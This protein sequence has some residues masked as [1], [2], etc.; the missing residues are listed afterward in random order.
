MVQLSFT[1]LPAILLALRVAAGPVLVNENP[2]T[3]DISRRF[4]FAGCSV[5][6]S[7]LARINAFKNRSTVKNGLNARNVISETV[8]NRAFNY[9]A[10]VGVGSPA[11]FY[12]LVVDTGSSNTWIG[13]GNNYVV[14]STSTQTS[15]S[16]VSTEYTDQVT[17]APGLV[18]SKQSIGVA[19][20]SSGFDEGID[21]I[22]GLGPV[23]LTAGTLSP[24]SESLIPTVMDNLVSQGT[25]TN[26][27]FGIS[28]LPA[29]IEDDTNGSIAFGGIDRTRFTG[30]I[31]YTPVTSTSP[32][33]GY[34]GHR[35]GDGTTS[36]L[37]STAGIVDTGSTL[38]HLATDGFNRY[39]SATG[40]VLDA[41]TG[42][43]TI[44]A[45]QYAALQNLNFIIDGVTY[46]LTPN[47]QIWPRSLNTAIN[48]TA[49]SIYLVV[50]D[51]G[52]PSGKGLD[53]VNGYAF[54]ERFYS[55]HD[56][57]NNRIGFATTPFTR[58]HTN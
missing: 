55:V 35:P 33:S 39:K 43:L 44:T 49:S 29:T 20:S 9:I 47:A 8:F 13:A 46:A 34:W 58:A 15:S 32:A 51:S 37:A 31:A 4:N 11:T 23:G 21:G 41:T 1:L 14:T 56:T 28:F 53:F 16:V 25:I 48:G 7:D 42:L 27:L 22:L 36:I 30:E 18:I 26:N 57:D 54:L 17:L 2:I 52:S 40:G 45:T 6:Q 19:S 12:D 38:I 24:D 3:L 50:I 10:T 5:V